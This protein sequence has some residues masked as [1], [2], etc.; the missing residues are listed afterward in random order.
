MKYDFYYDKDSIAN[1]DKDTLLIWYKSIP[2]KEAE[3]KVWIE[4]LELREVDC[5]R[6]KYKR[7]Q[8]S[9]TFENKAMEQLGE[10]SWIYLEPNDL[11]SAFYDTACKKKN[12]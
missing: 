10:S 12:R 11:D 7:L 6:R 1:P 4:Y 9:V 3:N 5:S 2:Q 8:G